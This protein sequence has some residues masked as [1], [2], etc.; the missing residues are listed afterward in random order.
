MSKTVVDWFYRHLSI[1]YLLRNLSKSGTNSTLCW[2][3][4]VQIISNRCKNIPGR[5]INIHVDSRLTDIY[6]E[7]KKYSYSG[8]FKKALFVE[9]K[10]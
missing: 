6:S 8:D 3:I 1:S 4:S 7:R 2:S 5:F 9:G 10:Q